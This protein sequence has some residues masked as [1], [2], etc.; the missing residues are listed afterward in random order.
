MYVYRYVRL[1]SITSN[2]SSLTFTKVIIS[3]AYP[4]VFVNG[5]SVFEI[6]WR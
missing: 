3:K 6:F 2:F 1:T 4:K 5:C